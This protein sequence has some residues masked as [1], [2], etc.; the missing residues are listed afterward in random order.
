MNLKLVRNLKNYFAVFAVVF[1]VER[2]KGKRADL[3]GH[4]RRVPRQIRY[5]YVGTPGVSA[6][7]IA[8]RTSTLGKLFEYKCTYNSSIS[9]KNTSTF[10][11][12]RLIHSVAPSGRENV[13]LLFFF[14]SISCAPVPRSHIHRQWRGGRGGRTRGARNVASLLSLVIKVMLCR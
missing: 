9:S 6:S 1:V 12:L 8:G 10:L 5:Y 3:L 11:F 2:I 13:R 4:A 7:P 14:F